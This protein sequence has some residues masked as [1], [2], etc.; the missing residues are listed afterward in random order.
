M[1]QNNNKFASAKKVLWNLANKVD[2]QRTSSM[3]GQHISSSNAHN[4][5]GCTKPQCWY[6]QNKGALHTNINF[7]VS[8]S[9]WPTL[10]YKCLDFKIY[11]K[12]VNGIFFLLQKWLN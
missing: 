11:T 7:K 6:V 5:S 4:P 3:N 12:W 8:K 9:V 1:V 10:K 2:E